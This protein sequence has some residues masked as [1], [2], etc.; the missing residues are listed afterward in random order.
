MKIIALSQNMF[1]TVDDED[2]EFLNQWKWCVA[3]N[4]N[5]YYAIKAK[6]DKRLLYMHRIILDCP[7]NMY[8]DHID[9]NGLNNQ[10]INLRICTKSQNSKNKRPSGRS[11]YL[12]V[13]YSSYNTIN[14]AIKINDKI[15]H[16]GTFNTEEEAAKKY[17]EFARIYHGEFANLNFK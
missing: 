1:T 3:K 12:G 8:I 11:K 14:A 9:H 15:K 5:T 6:K 2:Y 13:H 4:G 16:L 10:R 17:D 7:N